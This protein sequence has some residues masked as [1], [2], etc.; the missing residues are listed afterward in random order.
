[1]TTSDCL[2]RVPLF[3]GVDEEALTLLS[4]TV[5]D[6][7]F[8]AGDEIVEVGEVG[9]AMY[10]I[11]DGTVQVLYPSRSQD[12]ELARLGPG[13]VF[14]EMALLNDEPRSATVRAMESIHAL[15]LDRRRFREVLIASPEIA[16]KLLEVLSTRIRLADEQLSG[17][18]DKALRDGLTGLLNRRAF[19][20]RLRE[21]GDRAR[22]YGDSF[23]LVLLDVDN[24]KTVNDTLGHDVGDEVLRWL[25]RVLTEHTR[26]ADTAFRIGG[27]EF[28]ILAPATSAP[29]AHAVAERLLAMMAEATPPVKVQLHITCSAGVA[30][31]PAH[32]HSPETIFHQADQALLA[33]KRAGRNRVHAAPLDEPSSPTSE[34]E[35][36]P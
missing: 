33:A 17:L 23:A 24:F 13:D 28:A 22:R 34:T 32:G 20:E 7:Y 29:V 27:E 2:A 8:N 19:Q 5:R 10:L 11:L 35:G 36:V 4:E 21:E 31:C 18:S 30:A 3:Q 6:V 16:V 15:V 9:H 25:G 12:F 26:A 1:M 14:G